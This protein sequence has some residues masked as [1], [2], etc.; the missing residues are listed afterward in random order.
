M[1]DRN[2]RLYYKAAL[3]LGLRATYLPHLRCLQVKLGRR[4]Y[5][6][7]QTV[8]PFNCGASISLSKNKY[9]LNKLL[10]EAGFHVP[11]AIALRKELF[12]Q[13]PLSYF[14]R[15]LR[16]PLVAKPV[17]NTSRGKDVLC[18]IKD[19]Q[20]LAA[21]LKDAFK[22]YTA[23]QIEEF[24]Q[25]LK[26][27]RV[28]IFNKRVLGVVERFGAEVVGDACHTIQQL[29][30]RRNQERQKLSKHLTLSPLKID[31]EYERCLNEQGLNLSS[32]P[33][34]G[35]VI[36]LCHTVNT[37]RGGDF[38][39]KGKLIHPDNARYLCQ[40]ASITGLNM[41]GFDVLCQDIEQS[42]KASPGII[43]EANF[44]PDITIHEIP[45]QG[46][47][48]RVSKALLKH[49]IFRHPVSYLGHL[50]KQLFLFMSKG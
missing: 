47:K 21:Y 7:T 42:F 38:I 12:E 49:L 6:F 18:N 46:T 23:M 8:T 50:P 2:V 45:H 32:I 48:I 36:K 10:R 4:N 26:E 41:V 29:M 27:Y 31:I 40:A 34:L 15:H 1:I 11:K 17:S 14:I 37:G 20:S 9:Y 19:E 16:F 39:S 35:Q 24:H 43:I 30:E 33:P 28:L 5:Y 13:R 44:N 3:M 22:T 25:G